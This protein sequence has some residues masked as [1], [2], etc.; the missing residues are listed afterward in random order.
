M[1]SWVGNFLYYFLVGVSETGQLRG[2]VGKFSAGYASKASTY[3]EGRGTG[4]GLWRRGLA[5]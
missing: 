4:A 2:G 5:A 3:I 1:S